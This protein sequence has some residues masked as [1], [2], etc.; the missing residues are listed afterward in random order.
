MI[1]RFEISFL[2]E[3]LGDELGEKV[4]VRLEGFVIDFARIFE[5]E[6]AGNEEKVIRKCLKV[7]GGKCEE[8]IGI[9]FE[10]IINNV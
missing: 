2:S 3:K 8:F 5:F 7:R 6:F 9:S 4:M 1:E 10:K